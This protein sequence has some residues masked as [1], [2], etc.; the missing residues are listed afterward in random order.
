[1]NRRTFIKTS[2]TA[3]AGG[4]LF[5]CSANE[6]TV[7]SYLQDYASTYRTDPKAAALEWFKNAKFG[8]F[9]H[10][11]LYSLLARGEWVMLREQIPI[12]EYEPLKNQ[13]IAD[14]FDV[15]FITDLALEAGM[16]YITLTAKH[17]DGFC[18]F[19]TKQQ[20]YN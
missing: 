3:I 2:S 16:K 7:P 17:H 18:L 5:S 4:A 15:D 12:A 13:F 9:M 20:Q 1:M 14:K 19:G 10:Y 8:L 6:R 11:G